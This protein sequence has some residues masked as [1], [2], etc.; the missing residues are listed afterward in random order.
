MGTKA[1]YKMRDLV[2][3]VGILRTRRAVNNISLIAILA[4]C[5]RRDRQE[6]SR[7]ILK[8]SEI[9]YNFRKDTA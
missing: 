2:H 6:Y 3:E 9:I 7:T 5:R 8:L 4:S 1:V